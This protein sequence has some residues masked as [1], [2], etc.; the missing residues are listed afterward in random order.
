[1]MALEDASVAEKAIDIWDNNVKMF[2]FWGP[3]TESKYPK[4]KS[5][6]DFQDKDKMILRI[7]SF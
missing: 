4:C 7:I 2:E 6:K 5:H 1:M 3:L